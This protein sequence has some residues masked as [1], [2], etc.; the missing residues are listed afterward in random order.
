MMFV[1]TKTKVNKSTADPHL[2]GEKHTTTGIR[3]LERFPRVASKSS[4]FQWE[5]RNVVSYIYDHK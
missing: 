2:G 4:I 5:N 1:V 3:D